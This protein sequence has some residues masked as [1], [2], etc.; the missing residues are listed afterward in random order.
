MH[1]AG[2]LWTVA[3]RFGDI[4]I[5]FCLAWT[6]AFV[7]TPVTHAIERSFGVPR[8]LAAVGVYMVLFVVLLGSLFLIVPALIAQLV[9]L[10]KVLPAYAEQVSRTLAEIQADLYAR[11]VDVDITTI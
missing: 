11:N 2:L 4:I 5:I 1:L 6:P 10:G 8:V 7:L 3:E 9:A